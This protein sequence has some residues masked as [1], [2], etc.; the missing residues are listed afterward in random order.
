MYLPE[1]LQQRRFTEWNHL[2]RGL[3]EV[4]ELARMA[5]LEEDLEACLRRDHDGSLAE[6]LGKIGN[7][8]VSLAAVLSAGIRARESADLLRAV[9]HGNRSDQALTPSIIQ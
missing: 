4:W 2:V 3:M 7:E 6:L 9:L 1:A 8:C 5:G